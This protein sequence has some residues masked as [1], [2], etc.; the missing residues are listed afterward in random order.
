MVF[1]V[2]HLIKKSMKKILS[3]LFMAAFQM[4]TSFAQWSTVLNENLIIANDSRISNVLFDG[5]GFYFT[6]EDGS[7]GVFKHMVTR[8]NADGTPNWTSSQVA[9][10]HDLGSFTVSLQH[11]FV[12]ASGNFIRVSSYAANTTSGLASCANKISPTGTQMWNGQ[13]GVEFTD[14]AMGATIGA[15]GNLYV[16]VGSNLLKIN[17]QGQVLWTSA[18]DPATTNT[19]EGKIVELS[20]GSVGVAYYRPG[21]FNPTYGSY[22][23]SI[24]DA[25]GTRTT[26]GSQQIGPA[27]CSFYNPVYLTSNTNDELFFV[28]FDTNSSVAFVQKMIGDVPQ[29]AGN[30]LAFDTSVNSKFVTAFKENN[31]LHLLYKYNWNSSDEGGVKLQSID[32]NTFTT[33]YPAGSILFDQTT[34][35]VSPLRNCFN[36]YNGSLG[37]LMVDNVSKEVTFQT[38]LNG[39]L[40]STFQMCTSA[41]DKGLAALSVGA[42]EVVAFLEDYRN[43]ISNSPTNVAQN[44]NSG[45]NNVE[46]GGESFAL[47]VYPNPASTSFKIRVSPNSMGS[48]YGI[49]D[50]TGKCLERGVVLNETMSFNSTHWPSGM[51]FVRIGDH[52]AKV[53]IVSE[54]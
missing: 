29:L 12:D 31:T 37:F 32:L 15:S 45:G 11:S 33:V 8:L 52:V 18:L 36:S 53:S 19:R 54:N 41:S 42:G 34:T 44:L 50:M 13:L 6:W 1:N 43:G 40:S 17:D 14:G 47:S 3:V 51:Y 48:A 25:S 49:Y 16:L 20:D 46:E 10:S 39:A 22:Y 38:I 2:L 5:A 7:A 9:H 28:F 35:N 30:G 23:I 21:Q 4:S 27:S 26:T 24:F